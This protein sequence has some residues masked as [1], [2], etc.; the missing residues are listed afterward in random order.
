MIPGPLPQRTAWLHG[1][2]DQVRRDGLVGP[3]AHD[4]PRHRLAPRNGD[5]RPAPQHGALAV[6]DLPVRAAPTCVLVPATGSNCGVSRAPSWQ[7][8][9]NCPPGMATDVVSGTMHC[10]ESGRDVSQPHAIVARHLAHGPRQGL[11]HMSYRTVHDVAQGTAAGGGRW[12]LLSRQAALT[13]PLPASSAGQ[14]AAAASTRPC[15]TH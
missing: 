8:C 1:Q 3:Q 12:A 10:T 2:Q 14:S 11:C 5:E 15:R 13:R 9:R 4:V 6:V 7:V